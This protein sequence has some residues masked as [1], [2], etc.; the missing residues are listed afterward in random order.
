MLSPGTAV[1]PYRVVE[2]VG[3]TGTQAEV[4]RAQDDDGRE[5]ALKLLGTSDAQARREV[6]VVRHLNH[7]RIV[8]TYKVLEYKHRFCLVQEWVDGP[9]LATVLGDE[10]RLGL[11]QVVRVGEA[12]A[13]ALAYAHSLGVLHRDIKPSNVLRTADGDYKLVDFGAAGLLQPEVET[14][15]IG[16]IV[17]TPLYMSPE[18]AT[19]APQTTASDMFGLGLLLYRCLYGALPGEES[20]NYLQLLLTRTTTPIEVPPSPLRDLLR[21]CLAIDPAERPRSAREVLDALS[22]TDRLAP[23][24]GVPLTPIGTTFPQPPGSA[25]D[26]APRSAVATVL[27]AAAVVVVAAVLTWL[28]VPVPSG[29]FLLRLLIGVVVVAGALF[30]AYRVRQLV[31]P[32]PEAERRATGILTG[33][34]SRSALTES[35]VLEVDQVVTRLKSLDARFL[36]YTLVLLIR[37]AEEAKESAD[38]VAAL[39]QMVALMEKLTRQLLPWHVR[40]KEAIATSIAIVGSLAGVA[41]VVSGFLR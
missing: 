32:A 26:H 8:Q 38:R 6:D 40:H 33:A 30:T 15:Q 18:Q 4:Y 19:G 2:H 36:G 10:R 24:P 7:P 31:G 23:L 13:E 21:R 20:D 29:G 9:S 16:E 27:A 28:L 3:D 22:G 34:A 39:T 17:G 35:M 5:V 1:G 25:V 37:E 14:T 11:D 12:V 41:S